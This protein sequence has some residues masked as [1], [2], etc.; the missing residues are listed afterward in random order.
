MSRDS[1]EVR[2]CDRCKATVEARD[3][4]A[5]DGW[6]S[7]SATAQVF[8][9][10][11]GFANADLCPDCFTFL[12]DWFTAITRERDAQRTTAPRAE[13]PDVPPR[14]AIAASLVAAS[15]A[16][17]PDLDDYL[18]KIDAINSLDEMQEYQARN[19]LKL[20]EWMADPALA[21]RVRDGHYAAFERLEKVADEGE[22]A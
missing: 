19:G 8:G 18:A 1:I 14:K 9:E 5:F 2:E 6:G 15:L 4:D 10:R 17:S 20:M 12:L 21:E 3:L 13:R 11:K 22:P 16:S 7:A